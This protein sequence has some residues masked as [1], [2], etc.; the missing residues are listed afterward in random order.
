MLSVVR[1]SGVR[2]S[3]VAVALV[4]ACTDVDLERIA[5]DIPFRDDKLTVSGDLCT[6][7]PGTR[8]FPLRVLFVVDA[9]ESM[10]VTDPGDPV[11]GETGRERAVRT[12]YESLLEGGPE[13]V[14][15]GVIRF[16]AEASAETPVDQD[17]DGLPDT[18]YT[19]NSAQLQA[20]TA[21]LR[22][23]DRTT[24]YLNALSEAYFEMRT[25]L[26]SADLE[27]LPLSKY[28]IVFVSDGLPDTD[29]S[30]ERENS[31]ENILEAVDQ[32]VELA[33]L[34]RIGEFSL[35]TAYLSA[36]EGPAVD[37]AAQELLQTMAERGGGNYRNFRA[38]SR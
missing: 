26:T 31:T 29:S 32:L 14:R 17:M 6:R 28:A 12:T 3:L 8:V 30:E 38:V 4:T 7:D 25:E 11:S 21:S 5:A 13:G 35:H 16:S 37:Q 24:N 2:A 18:Y 9:S 36:G 10:L 34:F 33:D 15:V 22:V 1:S 23:T 20:A 19:A 27:S